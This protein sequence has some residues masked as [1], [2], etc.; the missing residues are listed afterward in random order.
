MVGLAGIV[1]SLIT[2]TC[3]EEESRELRPDMPELLHNG[4][5]NV[6][7]GDENNSTEEPSQETKEVR[8]SLKKEEKWR[9]T[10]NAEE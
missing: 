2:S 5:D 9:R 8:Q 3:P 1:L 6:A 7:S 4:E 10:K